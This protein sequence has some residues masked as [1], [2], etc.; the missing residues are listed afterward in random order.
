MNY[1]LPVTLIGNCFEARD[2]IHIPAGDK[3]LDHLTH[4]MK[5]DE[6]KNDKP[7]EANQVGLACISSSLAEGGGGMFGCAARCLS[8]RDEVLDIRVAPGRKDAPLLARSSKEEETQ[9]RGIAQAA[10][11]YSSVLRGELPEIMR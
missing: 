7:W 1:W 10:R 6:I 9:Q 8:T 2:S 3:L 5:P 4:W 11:V